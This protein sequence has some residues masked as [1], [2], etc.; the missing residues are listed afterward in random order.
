MDLLVDVFRW[1]LDP[2]NLSGASGVANRTFEHVQMLVYTIALA[3]VV[4][5]P[6]GMFIGHT[7][8]GEFVAISVGN[9]GR[10]LPSFGV[11]G[12]VF[13]FTLTYLPGIGFWPTFI[14]LFL[15]AIPPI[16]IS[17]YVG[18]KQVDP[19][20]VE[21][22]RG[23]GMSGRDLLIGLELPLAAPLVVAGLRTAALQVIATA[24]LGA[25]V[26]WG[27][28][29]RYIVDGLAQRDHVQLVAGA[30]LVAA[31]ALATEFGLGVVERLVAPRS[32]RKRRR[33][34]RASREHA[35]VAR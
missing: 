22:G 11:L 19:D 21:A 12:L 2:A 7:R 6:V 18:I 23:M 17:T 20:A 14:T 32:A 16:L 33:P 10:A 28:L 4:A 30:L 13:P 24:P 27:G 25:F 31:V 5:L 35:D 9:V 34:R 8:R 15:L 29:G 26:G 1:L 3:G